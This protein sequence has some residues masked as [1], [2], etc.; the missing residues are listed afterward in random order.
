MKNQEN[1]STERSDQESPSSQM[2]NYSG[3]EGSKGASSSN[4]EGTTFS[5]CTRM[6]LENDIQIDFVTII[7]DCINR[8][9]EN[10]TG[11]KL[12]ETLQEDMTPELLA[13]PTMTSKTG[14]LRA[15]ID[16]LD[17]LQVQIPPFTPGQRKSNVIRIASVIWSGDLYR[18]ERDVV[19]QIVTNRI[20][21]TKDQPISLSYVTPSTDSF[22]PP[23]HESTNRV[24][25]DNTVHPI[26]NG[27]NESFTPN[28]TY[29]RLTGENSGMQDH[30][31]IHINNEQNTSAP[32]SASTL[33][34]QFLQ[35]RQDV[36][37]NNN[38]FRHSTPPG[39]P[40][41]SS[42]TNPPVHT[43]S[44]QFSRMSKLAY[45]FSS[46]FKDD[47]NRY[48]G[49]I[50]DS[51]PKKLLLF[52]DVMCNYNMLKE[53]AFQF[54]HNLLS[55]EAHTFYHRH[56]KGSASSFD[57]AISLIEAHFHDA[58]AQERIVSK[59]ESLKF[60]EYSTKYSSPND[61]FFKLTA[62]IEELFPCTPTE[63]RTGYN[64]RRILAHAVSGQ[65]WASSTLY[66]SA[67]ELPDYRT[68]ASALASVLQKYVE[69]HHKS[70]DAMD[71]QPTADTF[72][73]KP[74]YGRAIERKPSITSRSSQPRK[75]TPSTTQ[76]NA[77][78]RSCFRCGSTKHFIRDCPEK[79]Y[80]QNV[81]RSLYNTNRQS[82]QGQKR[83]V[84]FLMQ[85]AMELLSMQEGDSVSPEHS[86]TELPEEQHASEESAS[87]IGDNHD[88]DD[89]PINYA[90]E[91]S[92]N[93]I[94]HSTHQGNEATENQLF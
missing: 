61:A 2:S 10:I 51:W 23:S 35:R 80:T 47:K 44:S 34:H 70:T 75:F 43:E 50:S 78:P 85:D 19:L 48:S 7:R 17:G 82:N 22:R 53:E 6:R 86:T 1:V 26:K 90:N 8:C 57:E 79:S 87:D 36:C 94:Y 60:E 12:I 33:Q 55:G 84:Y 3:N 81:L 5:F 77:T 92:D 9:G 88:K 58:P 49:H 64:K 42:R 13:H 40:T 59:L 83:S 63:Y 38:F 65:A 71:K 73:T 21:P 56:V 74:R 18:Y 37:Y 20:T 76:S 45:A 93:A 66:R 62:D 72:F 24:H 28:R 29:P 69:V 68:L 11:Q 14:L 32:Y 52:E 25:L 16:L 15:F 4:A 89:M 41:G 39:M 67:T 54:L 27:N 91:L 46:T 31:A 30:R